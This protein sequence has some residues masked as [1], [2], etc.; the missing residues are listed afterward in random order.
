[1]LYDENDNDD[2]DVIA[3]VT[4][5]DDDGDSDS[6]SDTDDFV[7]NKFLLVY[8]SDDVNTI[9]IFLTVSH[10]ARFYIYRI[11]IIQI[12]FIADQVLRVRDS[13]HMNAFV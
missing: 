9:I 4:A 1:M 8:S 2:V 7:N 5:V 13:A 12:S 3:I 6:D 10:Q 11:N